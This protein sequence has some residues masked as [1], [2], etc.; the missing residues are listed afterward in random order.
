[1]HSGLPKLGFA[2]DFLPLGFCLDLSINDCDINLA[3]TAAS[4]DNKRLKEW[5]FQLSL[6]WV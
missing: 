3:N 2:F 1:M 4:I 6:P 5:Y